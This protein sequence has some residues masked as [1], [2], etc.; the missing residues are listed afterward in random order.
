MNPPRD[1]KESCLRLS[2]RSQRGLIGF[3]LS[4]FRFL[5]SVSSCFLFKQDLFSVSMY[6][7]EILHAQGSDPA[8]TEIHFFVVLSG[9]I[10]RLVTRLSI[11]SS[12]KEPSGSGTGCPGRCWSHRPWRYSR[13]VE[14]WH[15]GMCLV[16]M[17][18]MGWRLD[19]MILDVF[20]N[21]NESVILTFWK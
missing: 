3:F 14:M 20:S 1:L 18:G 5:H 13:N 19:V 6:C 12:Q 4:L 17:G 7:R 21:L 15:W 10:V 16:G 8:C 2:T 11:I 9:K